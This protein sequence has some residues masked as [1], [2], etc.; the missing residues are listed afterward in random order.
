MKKVLAIVLTVIFALS[1]T[2]CLSA[3]GDDIKFTFGSSEQLTLSDTDYSNSDHW[4]SLGGDKNKSVDIFVI[5]PTVTF[6]LDNAD[7]P[8]VRIDSEQMYSSAMEWLTQIDSIISDCNVYAPL[9]SQLNAAAL[10]TLSTDEIEQQT[11][12]NP[13]NDIFAAFDYYLAN[14]NKGERPFILFGHSQGANLAIELATI[15]LGNKQYYS[16]NKNHIITYAIGYSVTQS[17]I[18]SNPNLKFSQSKNDTRVIVSWNT[19]APSEIASEAYKTFGTWKENALV[20]NPISW[21]NNETLMHASDNK[22]SM[23][24]NAGGTFSMVENY[25]NALVDKEHS[26]LVTTTVPEDDYPQIAPNMSRFHGQDIP[27]YYDSIVQ[28]ISDRISAFAK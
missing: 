28:N 8:F 2:F 13:R 5:Y 22:A 20:T 24:L 10:G 12:N 6:S 17:K 4:L 25:A 14:I 21:A 1:L 15:F 23:V 27:F 9:Y 11:H 3:C 16:H 26:V 19:T 18:D 7:L